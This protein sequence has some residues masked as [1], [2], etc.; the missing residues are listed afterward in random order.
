MFIQY[1]LEKKELCMSSTDKTKKIKQILSEAEKNDENIRKII[2]ESANA[3]TREDKEQKRKEILQVFASNLR[4]YREEAGL[5]KLQLGNM[6]G[7]LPQNYH[8]YESGTQEPGATTAIQMASILGISVDK[9]FESESSKIID[10]LKCQSWL[11]SVGFKTFFDNENTIVISAEGFPTKTV[12]IE[13]AKEIIENTK[14]IL[15]PVIQLMVTSETDKIQYNK[16]KTEH[17]KRIAA[18]LKLTRNKKTD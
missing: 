8:R 10:T 4:K 9:L 7:L 18:A 2:Y 16:N 14:Q 6:L 15:K 1:I 13:E 3:K 17:D 11:E 5:N 12:S